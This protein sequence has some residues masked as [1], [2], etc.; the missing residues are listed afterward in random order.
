[1]LSFARPFRSLIKLGRSAGSTLMSLHGNY[2]YNSA[3]VFLCF[4]FH[5]R[6]NRLYWI[7]PFCYEKLPFCRANRLR[8]QTRTSSKYAPWKISGLIS[9]AHA[10]THAP[11]GAQMPYI[12]G[13]IIER[14]D[15]IF[16]TVY[17]EKNPHDCRACS[18]LHWFPHFFAVNTNRY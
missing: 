5:H 15:V 8:V 1:M 17:S 14:C 11:T 4:S 10:R 2:L 16:N 9:T 6:E 3:F 13:Q 12:V 7:T 18:K